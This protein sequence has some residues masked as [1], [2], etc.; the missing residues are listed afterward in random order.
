MSTPLRWE[1]E[2][3]VSYKSP[4]QY[5]DFQLNNTWDPNCS[6]NDVRFYNESGD[7]LEWFFPSGCYSGDFDQYGDLEA[8][9]NHPPWK[10]QLT[11]FAGV[12]VVF[13]FNFRID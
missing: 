10:R 7:P 1:R 5:L 9:G 8:F 3:T 11:K 4:V 12:Q 2:Y 13:L 6:L